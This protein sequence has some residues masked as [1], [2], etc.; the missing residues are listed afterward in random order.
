M[1]ISVED[2]IELVS[3][4]TKDIIVC[5]PSRDHYRKEGDLDNEYISYV[6]AQGL[7]EDLRKLQRGEPG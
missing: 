3:A 5:S 7:V 6:D 1:N 2:L 4:N